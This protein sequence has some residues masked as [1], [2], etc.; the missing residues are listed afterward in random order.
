MSLLFQA[1][2]GLGSERELTPSHAPGEAIEFLR[3]VERKASLRSEAALKGPTD[4]DLRAEPEPR[5]RTA[6]WPQAAGTLSDTSEPS[7]A[8]ADAAEP[9][10]TPP[11]AV[12]R[13]VAVLR[14]VLPFVERTLPLLEGA[15]GV[16]A[17]NLAAPQDPAAAPVPQTSDV[18]RIVEH[19]AEF[20]AQC[21][22]LSDQVVEQNASLKRAENG[23][24][25]VR[26]AT[27]RNTRE[28]QELIEDLRRV[29]NKVNFLALVALGL[30][31]ITLVINIA[32]YLHIFNLR[33]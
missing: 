11:T 23:L 9:A 17:S 25:L 26:E 22:E 33:P 24:G 5:P 19:I 3:C 27:E 8:L 10:H 7:T 1:L 6:A 32:L 15:T 21:C 28:Q 13:I 18:A 16:T 20:K 14:M 12:K 4:G 29:G 31:G 2:Q 30:L